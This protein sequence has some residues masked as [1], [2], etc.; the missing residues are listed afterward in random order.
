MMA[1]ACSFIWLFFLLSFLPSIQ[2][3]RA[4]DNNDVPTFKFPLDTKQEAK[5]EMSLALKE[6]M[7]LVR[8]VAITSVPCDEVRAATNGRSRLVL[9][10][11]STGISAVLPTTRLPVRSAN[12]PHDRQYSSR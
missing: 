11:I 12:L 5:D 9:I 2:I 1:F 6:A 10:A 3:C 4:E 7:T 8:F